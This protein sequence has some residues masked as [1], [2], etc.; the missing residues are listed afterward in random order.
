MQTGGGGS[1]LAGR[2]TT[3]LQQARVFP[4]QKS[5]KAEIKCT[6]PYNALYSGSSPGNQRRGFKLHWAEENMNPGLPV[7]D[8]CPNHR[9]V[10]VLSN[11]TVTTTP[12]F[13]ACSVNLAMKKLCEPIAQLQCMI[14]ELSELYSLLCK[15]MQTYCPL[16]KKRDLQTTQLTVLFTLNKHKYPLVSHCIKQRY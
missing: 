12:C 14:C 10:I 16:S 7:L 11:P 5:C 13:G 6:L 4:K 1:H 3:L 2:N 9:E 15:C 8:D